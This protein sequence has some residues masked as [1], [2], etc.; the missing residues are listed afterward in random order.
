VI[1]LVAKEEHQEIEFVTNH[2]MAAETVRETIVKLKIVELKMNVQVILVQT[3][4]NL[5]HLT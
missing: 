1:Q 5:Q 4:L 2:N 3:Q